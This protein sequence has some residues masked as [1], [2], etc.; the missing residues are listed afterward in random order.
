MVL[1]GALVA[2]IH[3]GSAYNT[4][5]LMNGQWIP[6]E[7]LLIDPWWENFLHNMATVQLVHRTSPSR[8]SR[9]WPRRGGAC[10]ATGGPGGAR[11]C[12]PRAAVA[13]AAAQ[14]AVGIAT[15]LLRVP[16]PLAA[17]HQA[18]AV[19]VFTCALGLLHALR[20]RLQP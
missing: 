5:P 9:W 7:I 15:L 14:I 1:S 19:I 3:A 16:L 20:E 6:D 13:A 4:F 8:S 12:G 10:A 2:A 17:I 18:G 11:A